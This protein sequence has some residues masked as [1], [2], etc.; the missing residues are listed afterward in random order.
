[1]NITAGLATSSSPRCPQCQGM[2]FASLPYIPG[3]TWIWYHRCE[4]CGHVWTLH[5]HERT[6]IPFDKDAAR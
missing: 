3:P 6:L 2:K 4:D 1:M 5:N